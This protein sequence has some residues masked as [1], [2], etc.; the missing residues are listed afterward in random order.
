VCKNTTPALPAVS[1]QTFGG[2]TDNLGNPVKWSLKQLSVRCVLL[3]T[4]ASNVR[5]SLI[6]ANSFTYSVTGLEPMNKKKLEDKKVTKLKQ[7]STLPL[8]KDNTSM[9]II[10][11]CQKTCNKRDLLEQFATCG[12]VVKVLDWQSRITGSTPSQYTTM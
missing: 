11:Q 7:N 4:K 3:K 2:P 9:L 5:Q 8:K 12:K 10:K 1:Y 6:L